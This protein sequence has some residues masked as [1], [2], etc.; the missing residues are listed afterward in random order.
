M[1][2]QFGHNWIQKIPLT[3]KLDSACCLVQFLLSSAF[4]SSNYFHFGQH[5]VLSHILIGY[6]TL[7]KLSDFVFKADVIEQFLAKRVCTFYKASN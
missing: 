5:V 1:L 3:A 4:F 7:H 2:V 6:Q